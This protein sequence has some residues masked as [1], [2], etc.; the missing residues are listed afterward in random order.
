[1]IGK[2]AASMLATLPQKTITTESNLKGMA[3]V[4][5]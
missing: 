2:G 3:H 4:L 5:S 1:M